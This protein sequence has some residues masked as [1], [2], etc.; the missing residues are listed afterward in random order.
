MLKHPFAVYIPKSESAEEARWWADV[1]KAIAAAKGWPSDFIRCMALV[2]SHPLAY[3]MEEFL[4]E[5][6]EHIVGLNLVAGTTWRA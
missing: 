4:F 5:L 3:Q 2:E 1:F 6:R